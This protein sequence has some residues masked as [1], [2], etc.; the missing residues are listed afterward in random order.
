MSSAA[1]ES[2]QNKESCKH[3][4]S[5]GGM[6]SNHLVEKQSAISLKMLGRAV[7][8]LPRRCCPTTNY[9]RL[10]SQLARLDEQLFFLTGERVIEAARHEEAVGRSNRHHFQ[11]LALV[12]PLDTGLHQLAPDAHALRLRADCQAANLRQLPRIYFQCRAADDLP[13]QF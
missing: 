13:I 10:P 11:N 1:K 8:L 4:L 12:R 6:V 9:E 7:A 3:F 2:R 5:L